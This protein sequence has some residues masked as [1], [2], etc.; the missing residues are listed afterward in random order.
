[1]TASATFVVG[2]AG[3][4]TTTQDDGRPG[5]L[6]FGIPRSGPVDRSSYEAAIRSF[7]GTAV[8][9]AIEMSSGGLVLQCTQGQVAFALCGG[10]FT[11]ELDGIRLGSWVVARIGAGMTLRVK[12][13]AGHWGYLAFAGRIEAPAW[14]GSISRHVQAGL[15]GHRLVAGDTLHVADCQPCERDEGMPRAAPKPAG[16][17]RPIVRARVILGPQE[18]FFGPAAID[19][20][21][22]AS[23]HPSPSFDR[24]GLV[25]DGPVIMPDAIDMPSEPAVRGA[26]QVDGAG[27]ATLLLADHQ[28]SGGY[29]KVAVMIGADVDRVA[30]LPVGSAFQLVALDVAAA[31]RAALAE[32]RAREQYHRLLG[33]PF[34]LGARLA[35][36]NLIDGAI[37]A[38]ED[39]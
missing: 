5:L 27:R 11:A 9:G 3:P 35:D 19:T 31:H 24:M 29:P 6:R 22:T 25:L 17:D 2:Q 12:A 38:L 10:G 14:L 26:L 16:A 7:G 34:D 4:L 8:G 13:G 15:G 30:Q 36:T 37:D 20:L 39:T 18:R 1:V 32:R 21:L 33:Q 28:A 23:F